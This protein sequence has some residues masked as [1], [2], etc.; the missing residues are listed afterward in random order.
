MKRTHFFTESAKQLLNILPQDNIAKEFSLVLQHFLI[1]LSPTPLS[2]KR[3]RLAKLATRLNLLSTLEFIQWLLDMGKEMEDEQVDVLGDF[4]QGAITHGEHGQFFTPMNVCLLMAQ[5]SKSKTPKPTV[6][7]PACGS[8]RTLIAY[9][10]VHKPKN[11]I[12][13]GIDKS[14]TC[15]RMTAINMCMFGMN[16]V[17]MHGNTLSNERW[18]SYYIKPPFI[19][20]VKIKKNNI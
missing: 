16:G 2:K 11:T 13:T 4:F 17:T 12:Y 19:K 5:L 14:L 7:D 18:T 9:H 1:A 20:V 8:G 15:V 10:L 3:A 6:N